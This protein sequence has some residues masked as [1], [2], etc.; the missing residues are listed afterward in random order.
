MAARNCEISFALSA[1]AVSATG[2]VG[3]SGVLGCAARCSSD[4]PFAWLY[5]PWVQDMEEIRQ[6]A[7]C[8]NNATHLPLSLLTSTFAATLAPLTP[9]GNL[10]AQMQAECEGKAAKHTHCLGFPHCFLTDTEL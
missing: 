6:Q 8:S 2:A 5:L 4:N 10:Q 9:D 7:H 3:S 1:L